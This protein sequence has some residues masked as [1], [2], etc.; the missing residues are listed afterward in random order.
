MTLGQI[1]DGS[2]DTHEIAA[3]SKPRV[4]SEIACDVQPMNATD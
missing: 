2:E 3:D 1:A 4:K